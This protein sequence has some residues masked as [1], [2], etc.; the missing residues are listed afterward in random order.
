MRRYFSHF[1]AAPSARLALSLL[2]IVGCLFAIWI[3]AEA[4]FSRLLTRAASINA[5]P[6]I[7]KKAVELMSADPESHLTLAAVLYNLGNLGEAVRELEYAVSL[8]P[9]DHFAW[10]ELGMVKDQLDDATGALSALNES[11]RLAPY[12]ASPRWQ[13]GNVLLRMGRYDEAFADLR[14]AGQS[15]PELIPNVIDLA[16]GVSKGN[17]QITEDWAQINTSKTRLA[18][19]RLLLRQNNPREATQKFKDARPV[20]AEITREFVRQ[21]IAAQAYQEAFEV[22]HIARF[23]K[24]AQA[25]TLIYDGGFEAALS[26]DEWGFGWRVPAETGNAKPSLD[27]SQKHSGAQSFLIEFRGNSPPETP[28]VSQFVIVEPSKR[29]RVSFAARTQDLV[30]G[31]L[32]LLIVTDAA[33]P[34]ARLGQSTALPQGT[35]EWQSLSFDFAAGAATT[36]VALRLQRLPC[37]TSPCPVFGSIWLDSVSIEEVKWLPHQGKY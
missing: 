27:A 32:P 36:A 6:A 13:R 10:L 26:L 3:S 4:G 16:W 17:M 2:G 30:S 22:W 20:S 37:S 5:N 19:A 25:T 31:G 15:N 29:Y 1:V 28:L 23:G 9:R 24:D 33:L 35:N 7:A 21:L 34:H 12:Y 11:V 8:R 18:F 14:R